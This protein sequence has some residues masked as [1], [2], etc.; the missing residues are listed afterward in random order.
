MPITEFS[1]LHFDPAVITLDELKPIV[2]DAKIAMESFSTYPFHYYIQAADDVTYL[3]IIGAWDSLEQHY[4]E[5]IV[6]DANKSV[7]GRL[8]GKVDVEWLYHLS[9]DYTADDADTPFGAPVIS[10]SRFFAKPGQKATIDKAIARNNNGTLDIQSGERSVSYGWR[11]DLGFDKEE[12]RDVVKCAPPV[13]EICVFSDLEETIFSLTDA[14]ERQNPPL[15]RRALS[16]FS[17]VDTKQALKW[18]V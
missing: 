7:L 8:K 12:I 17:S 11:L 6:S 16:Y 1:L 2:R 14:T 3:Y 5:W 9:L 13:D 15:S 4:D 10:I 18:D